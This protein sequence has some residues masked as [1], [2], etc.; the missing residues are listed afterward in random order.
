MSRHGGRLGECLDHALENDLVDVILVA[1]NFGQDPRFYENFTQLRSRC[2]PARATCPARESASAGRRRRR[3]ENAD[4]RQAERLAPLRDQRRD[5]CPG[6]VSLGALE[7]ERRHADHLDEERRDDRRVPR[8][9]RQRS[10]AHDGSGA[11]RA[12]RLA[13]QRGALPAGPQRVRRGLPARRGDPRGPSNAH[14]R[15][16]LRGPCVRSGGLCAR[17]LGYAHLGRGHPRLIYVS[18]MRFG[19]DGPKASWKGAR[20]GQVGWHSPG[21]GLCHRTCPNRAK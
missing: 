4:G 10:G 13:E 3:H 17:G 12:L 6:G 19:Q 14:V 8:S 2:Q 11:A 18:I 20:F 15:D 21:P 9:I 7:P 5:L 16:G 1:Y